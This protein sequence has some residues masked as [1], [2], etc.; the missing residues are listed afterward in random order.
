MQVG[1]IVAYT[2]SLGVIV[3]VST[4]GH[5]VVEWPGGQEFEEIKAEDLII[6][7]LPEVETPETKDGEK[8]GN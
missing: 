7:T 1:D 2:G 8:S 5:P 3:G 4:S 6:V